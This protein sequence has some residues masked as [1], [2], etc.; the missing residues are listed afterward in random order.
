MIN[1]GCL[2]GQITQPGQDI[3]IILFFGQPWYQSSEYGVK[4]FDEP[5]YS[6]VDMDTVSFWAKSYKYGFWSCA[7]VDSHLALAVGTSNYGPYV[8]HEH[9]QEWA[10]MVT[11]VAGYIPSIS[12]YGAIDNELPL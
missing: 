12:T 7:P 9:G 11:D 5:H 10:R 2:Q 8:G 6:F 3:A 1:M 4:I